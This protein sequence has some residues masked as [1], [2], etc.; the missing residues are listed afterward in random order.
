LDSRAAVASRETD[1]ALHDPQGDT[2]G[3]N[4]GVNTISNLQLMPLRLNLR[5]WEALGQRQ[6]DLLQRLRQAGWRF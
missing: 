3:T 4:E 5:Q 2:S 6:L 1:H